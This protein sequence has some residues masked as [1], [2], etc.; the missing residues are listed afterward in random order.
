MDR[1]EIGNLFNLIGLMLEKSTPMDAEYW[2]GYYEGIKF[3]YRGG[4]ITV[5]DHYHIR[6][7]AD[8][9]HGDP[10]HYAYVRGYRDG[11]D[12]KEP[13]FTPQGN[14]TPTGTDKAAG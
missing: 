5:R 4:M 9:A 11:C 1:S 7:I 6:K 8:M 3:Y 2:R 14:D 13:Q 10:Y 12:G